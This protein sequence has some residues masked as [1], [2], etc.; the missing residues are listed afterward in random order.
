ML[1][2]LWKRA[3][4]IAPKQRETARLSL[5]RALAVA[6]DNLHLVRLNGGLVI[7]LESDILDQEGPNIVTEPV[8]VKMALFYGTNPCQH[9]AHYESHTPIVNPSTK[10]NAG[11]QYLES[12]PSADLV[13]ENLCDDTVIVG[14]DFHGQ[15]WLNP[16]LVDQII[17]RIGER[18]PETAGP[19]SAHGARGKINHL[20]ARLQYL[21]PR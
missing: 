5:S 18:E 14:E 13:C 9:I 15:L 10:R 12:Q 21:L 20:S 11:Q 17:E 3:A 6:A 1:L 4:V 8:G 2:L 19:K 16:T 7:Q